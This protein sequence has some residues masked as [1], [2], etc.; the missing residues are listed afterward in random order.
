MKK[1]FDK[2]NL[3]NEIPVFPLSNA[4][5]FPKTLLPLNIFEPRYKQ[6]TEHAMNNQGLIGMVQSK[7]EVDENNRRKVFDIGC[8]GYI[9][10]H[11]GTPDGRYLINLKGITRFKIK[12]EIETKNLY[13]TFEVNYDQFANDFDEEK[14]FN[15]NTIDL[16]DKTRKLFEK[17]QLSTDW[18]VIEKVEPAQLINSL[19]MICPFTISEKQRLLETSNLSERNEVLNQIINFYILSNA[20]ENRNIH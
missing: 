7:Q 3:P 8:I 2:N 13:R 17:N 10:Y 6:M 15:L 11:S 20:E 19:A 5:F 18:K 9:E 4:I 16:I 1:E 14:D 12:K